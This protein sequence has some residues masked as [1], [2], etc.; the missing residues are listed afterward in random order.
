METITLDRAVAAAKVPIQHAAEAASV[1]VADLAAEARDI[2]A[3]AAEAADQYR[4]AI[5]HE[6]GRARRRVDYA[7]QESAYR[8]QQAPFTAVAVAC[9][10]G[11]LGGAAAAWAL[12]RARAGC[13]K[14]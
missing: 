7:R 14:E 4:I 9:A 11:F 13:G 2:R 8:I 5:K 6:V 3:R 10:A 1:H 12:M